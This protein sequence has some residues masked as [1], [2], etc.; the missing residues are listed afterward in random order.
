MKGEGVN[1][2]IDVVG[3]R[4]FLRHLKALIRLFS[5]PIGHPHGKK[6]QAEKERHR[7]W[8]RGVIGSVVGD[9]HPTDT[10]SCEKGV[11]SLQ[12]RHEQF[13]N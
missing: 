11:I 1:K 5:A 4:M 12:H 10:A 3:G 8:E 13:N 9:F 6:P 7:S 2:A